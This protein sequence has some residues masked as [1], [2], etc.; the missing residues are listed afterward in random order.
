M[1]KDTKNLIKNLLQLNPLERLGVGIE[2][3]GRCYSDL[4]SHPFFKGV[5]F[6]KMANR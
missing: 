6:Y 5:D 4:K 1:D 2:G 3:S